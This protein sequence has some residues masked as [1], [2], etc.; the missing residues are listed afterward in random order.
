[1]IRKPHFTLLLAC[2][3]TLLPS[4]GVSQESPAVSGEDAEA[5]EYYIEG[6]T[7]F[8][9]EE[10][11][12][13]LDK[14]TAAHL[15]NSDDP[16]INYAL[17]DVYLA[18]GDFTNAEYYGQIAADLKPENKWYQV[19]LAEIY[20]RSGRTEQAISALQKV[21]ESHSGDT[22]ILYRLSELYTEIGQLENSNEVL[23]QIIDKRGPVFELHL[24][25]FQNFNALGQ[26]ENALAELEKMRELKPDNLTTL[27]AM[28]RYYMELGMV[29]KAREVLNDA[30]VRNPNDV[31]TLLLLAEIYIETSEWEKLGD[32]FASMM[33][34]RMI[35]PAQKM[36]LVRFMLM[37][38]ESD[39]RNEIISAQTERIVEK[40]TEEEAGYAPAHLISAD[41]YLRNGQNSK[42]IESLEQA[43]DINPDQPQAWVQRIQLLFGSER[44]EEVLS[45]TE[46][47]EE[48]APDNA[49]IQFF[50]GA[51]HMFQDNYEEAESWLE[52][53]SMAPAQRNIRSVIYGTLGDVKEELDKWEEA[54]SA[55]ERSIRLDPDNTTA[56]NNYAYYLSLREENLER[57][58]EMAQKAV[59]SNP[60]N[61]SF[62][63]TLGW[64]HFKLGNLDEALDYIQ[65]A[66]E[67]G[68]A[69]AEVYEHLGD[70]YEAQGLPEKAAEWW[71]KALKMDE[72][73][74]HLQEKL[75]YDGTE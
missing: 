31:G 67:T 13:A 44:Y 23:Q 59:Q 15:K 33:E 52:R 22:D 39:S 60:E 36:E 64:V 58:L 49:F 72:D 37:K 41:Y 25:R 74:T 43:I 28:S 30:F 35:A 27:Q 47:A 69:S 11:E 4:L 21:S 12:L 19:H 40:L 9:N 6:I 16:G 1:M 71:E 70:V 32:T 57:A 7:H 46:R 2:M 65:R 34:N 51:S 75:Q 29:E 26:N 42:A 66:V 68:D 5:L 18:T 61:S 50:T 8:E 56:L 73:R 14:L 54:E 62:L 20:T 45:L 24:R 38:Q 17:S 3:L 53:A 63:D 10:Y 55:L 48:Y